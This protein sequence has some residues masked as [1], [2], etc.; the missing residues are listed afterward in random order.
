MKVKNKTKQSFFACFLATAKTFVSSV[1]IAIKTFFFQLNQE[2][3]EMET[4]LEKDL[5]IYAYFW[6]SK[7][8][9]LNRIDIPDFLY[10]LKSITSHMVTQ[11][12]NTGVFETFILTSF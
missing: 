6:L 7:Y 12:L 4:F 2:C 3:T 8:Y 11:V 5:Y 9:G 1:E 10:W